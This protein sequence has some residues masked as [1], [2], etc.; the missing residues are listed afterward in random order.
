[1]KIRLSRFAPIIFIEAYLI[2]TLVIFSVG[3]ID[4]HID[5]PFLFWGFIVSYHIF[6][7]LGYTLGAK[8]KLEMPEKDLLHSQMS[9]FSVKIIVCLAIVSSIM[10]MK[11]FT[12]EQLFNPF[13]IYES[14]LEGITN[15]GDAYTSKMAAETS[16]GGNKIFNILLFLIAFS[17][18]ICIPIIVLNWTRL[19]FGL[20]AVGLFATLLPV[21]SAV[22]NGTNKSVFDF[23]IYYSGSL[24]AIFAYNRAKLGSYNVGNYKF[25]V[26][27]VV[28]PCSNRH[29]EI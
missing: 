11:Q 29:T 12:I 10:T 17:K 26:A 13:F 14:V 4:Y 22:S 24:L 18:I 16:S 1:M 9:I 15:P 6:M 5:S 8:T 3:P 25:F 23:F 19:S 21:L 7:V 27:I 2:L 28:H 20:K